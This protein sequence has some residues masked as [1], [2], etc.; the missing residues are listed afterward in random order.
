MSLGTKHRLNEAAYL[1]KQHLGE[2]HRDQ[3]VLVEEFS[4]ESEGRERTWWGTQSADQRQVN[5]EMLQRVDAAFEKW[6]S[7]G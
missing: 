2:R 5:V 6:L 1:C 7:G 3:L 4:M